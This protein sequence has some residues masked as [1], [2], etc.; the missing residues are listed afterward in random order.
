MR[1]STRRVLA[2]CSVVVPA[3]SG[4]AWCVAGHPMVG[5]IGIATALLNAGLQLRRHIPRRIPTFPAARRRA[6]YVIDQ[7]RWP[8]NG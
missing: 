1:E 6:P 8:G 5:G 7:L 2:I 4:I 3:I